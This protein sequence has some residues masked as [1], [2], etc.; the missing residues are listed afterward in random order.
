MGQR[1]SLLYYPE[2]EATNWP[3]EQVIR[4]SVANRKMSGGGNRTTTGATAQAILISVLRTA[5]QR[6]L[7]VQ[8]LLVELQRSSDQRKFAALALGP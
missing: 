2:I 8:K 1:E 5:W 7:D 3:G 6:K 4:P